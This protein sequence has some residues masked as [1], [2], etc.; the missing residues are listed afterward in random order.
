MVVNALVVIEIAYLFSVR[1]VHGPSL[2]WRGALG[3]PIVWLGLAIIVAAQLAFAYAPLLQAV[4]GSAALGPAEAAVAL[5]SSD[6]AHRGG[7]RQAKRCAEGWTLAH[8]WSAEAPSRRTDPRVRD[9]PYLRLPARRDYHR[10]SQIGF[11]RFR[12]S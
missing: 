3:T 12:S 5:G 8:S 1:Y 2:T 11:S 7:G 6:A 10:L 9:L 4:F